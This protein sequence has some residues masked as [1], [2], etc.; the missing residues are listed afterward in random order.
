[1]TWEEV[2]ANCLFQYKEK[3]L[4]IKPSHTWHPSL[5]KLCPPTASTQ[6]LLRPSAFLKRRLCRMQKGTKYPL[7]S[8]GDRLFSIVPSMGSL[9]LY[10]DQ[11]RSQ[12]SAIRSWDHLGLDS[13]AAGFLS[14]E[15]A[16]LFTRNPKVK[17]FMFSCKLSLP[18]FLTLPPLITACFSLL[19]KNLLEDA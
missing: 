18:L 16:V 2:S 6:P 17:C 12:N 13:G 4:T 1:M 11:T 14:R 8:R 19:L 3:N 10:F 7:Q 15:A 5:Q 9:W